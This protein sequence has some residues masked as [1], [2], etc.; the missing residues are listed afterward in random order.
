M[1]DKNQDNKLEYFLSQPHQPFFLL[2][3]VSAVIFMILFL[4]S[5]RGIIHTNPT[6]LHSYSMIFI[7]FTNV[8]YGFTLTTFTRFSS[9]MPI[10]QKRYI[11]LFLL[12]SVAFISM[13]AQVWIAY[14]FFAA[15]IAMAISFAYLIR[16][17]Y[18]IY[19]KAPEPKSDQYMIVFAFSMG[20]LSNILFLLSQIPCSK[21]KPYIFLQYGVQ[22]GIYLYILLLGIVIAF[23]MVPFFS[24]VMN[25]EKSSYLHIS[26][27]VLFALHVVTSQMFTGWLW[28][29]DLALA[30]LL[31]YELVKMDLPF[32]NSD[33]L[34]WGLHL[35][36]YW[37]GFGF[38]ISSAVEF[39]SAHYG[40]YSLFM[41]IHILMLGFLTSILIAF[42]TRVTLGHGGAVLSVG[43]AT[44]ALFVF[45]QIVVAARIILSITASNGKIFPMFDISVTL[46]I[47]L[48]LWW[49][50]LYGRILIFGSQRDK[51]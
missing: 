38:L 43:K 50:Y 37:L 12:N 19:Q 14:L 10:E 11:T 45:I 28:L 5:Y 44:K 8:F 51:R 46:W 4:L 25:Y 26:L 1:R 47:I 42:G 30:L 29:A 39:F 18:E 32:P 7:V 33:P 22:T 20:E 16:I 31:T 9:Q 41:P 21:C 49:S 36:V 35:A 40:Y 27:V 24:R 2:G 15:V 13:I 48:F 34:L 23:R 17:F 3:I 6:L